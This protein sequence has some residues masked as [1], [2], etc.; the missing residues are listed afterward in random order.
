MHLLFIPPAPINQSGRAHTMALPYAGKTSQN[1]FIGGMHWP[2]GSCCKNGGKWWNF[3]YQPQ[4]KVLQNTTFDISGEN[5]TKL[6]IF[7]RDTGDLE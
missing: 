3:N 1:I 6:Y 5:P 4:P 7:R 2:S